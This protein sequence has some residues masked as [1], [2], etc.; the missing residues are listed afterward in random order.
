MHVDKESLELKR[1]QDDETEFDLTMSNFQTH[2]CTCKE[3]NLFRIFFLKLESS[4]KAIERTQLAT[5]MY[6]FF[7]HI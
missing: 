3:D 5:Q 7:N 1:I 2:R 6:F 4:F